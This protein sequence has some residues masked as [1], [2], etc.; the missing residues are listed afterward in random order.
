MDCST[1]FFRGLQIGTCRVQALQGRTPVR[2][3]C[4]E[5][6]LVWLNGKTVRITTMHSPLTGDTGTGDG[7]NGPPYEVDRHRLDR[8]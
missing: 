7:R 8:P 1:P 2:P 4:N 6:C 3:P 5:T